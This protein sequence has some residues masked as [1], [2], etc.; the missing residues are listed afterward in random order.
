MNWNWPN[1]TQE[2][3][4]CPHCDLFR[5]HPGFLD[6]LQELRIVLETLRPS[7]ASM[8][9]TSGCR[10]IEHN[11]NIGGHPRSLHIGDETQHLGQQGA[12]AVDV[13]TPDG[14]FRGDLFMLAWERNWSLG[15]NAKRG[16]LHLDQ[17]V[18]VGL[19]QNSFDY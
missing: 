14:A 8:R 13:A 16:F 7:R 1:F 12:L 5:F 4:S 19:P 3:L 18:M 17:R 9:V 10:C 6:R 11:R 15:W 2:E